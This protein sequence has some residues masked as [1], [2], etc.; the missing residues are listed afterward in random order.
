MTS[1]VI[2]HYANAEQKLAE[3]KQKMLTNFDQQLDD[4]IFLFLDE[5]RIGGPGP[6]R[7]KDRLTANAAVTDDMKVTEEDIKTL[8]NFK[9]AQQICNKAKC[10]L[11]LKSHILP[12]INQG[13][14]QCDFYLYVD[15]QGE[16]EVD[17]G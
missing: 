12:F 2:D 7:I 11:T 4:F 1:E 9:K 17:N 13:L 16:G 14:V 15:R 10:T 6:I 8:A 5:S 3:L